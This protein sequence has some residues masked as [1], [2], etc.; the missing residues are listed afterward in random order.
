[1][2]DFEREITGMKNMDQILQHLLRII[3]L[4]PLAYQIFTLSQI[5]FV[6]IMKSSEESGS[7]F[8]QKIYTRHK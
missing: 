3:S 6:K 2:K 1:M 4:T 8:K 5:I 7:R